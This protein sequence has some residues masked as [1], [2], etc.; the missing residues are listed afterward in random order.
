MLKWYYCIN[1]NSDILNDFIESMF[2]QS[3]GKCRY[4]E[5]INFNLLIADFSNW[6]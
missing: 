6:F 1:P 3:F 2:I 5:Y 4:F